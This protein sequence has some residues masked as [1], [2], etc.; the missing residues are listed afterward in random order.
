MSLS[1]FTPLSCRNVQQ[2][3]HIRGRLGS[4][5]AAC[6]CPRLSGGGPAGVFEPR[7]GA[8]GRLRMRWD[9]KVSG[10]LEVVLGRLVGVIGAWW[11]RLV[12]FKGRLSSAFGARVGARPALDTCQHVL[13]KRCLF[14]EF[15]LFC[16]HLF[17]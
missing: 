8:F 7:S 14:Y 17:C 1:R 10:R 11:K 15:T 9:E 13:S 4:F 12:H 5:G 6:G 16:Y 2:V 3:S